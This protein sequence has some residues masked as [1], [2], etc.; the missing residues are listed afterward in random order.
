MDIYFTA[1]P[2][3][4]QNTF[5]FTI[6]RNEKGNEIILNI[7]IIETRLERIRLSRG[8]SPS[9]IGDSN[10]ISSRQ[11]PPKRVGRMIYSRGPLLLG[12][13]EE[14][15]LEERREVISRKTGS[16][17][18]RQRGSSPPQVC[19]ASFLAPASFLPSF[20]PSFLVARAA[21]AATHTPPI[22]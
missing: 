3:K 7:P 17:S 14:S 21:I 10:W 2:G 1:R 15:G 4:F 20:L 6:E 13:K 12:R 19:L 8:I 11:K 9:K 22:L 5:E 16:T 18:S